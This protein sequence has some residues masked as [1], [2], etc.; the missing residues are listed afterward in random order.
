MPEKDTG[1][2]LSK[3][4]VFFEKARKIA[5]TDNFDYAI[6]MYME[7]LRCA[8]DAV[9]EGHVK[10]REMAFARKMKG[11]AGPSVMD[12]IKHMGGKAPL[13]RMIN[14]EYLFAKDP[15]NLKYAEAILNAA[16]SGGYKE[17]VKWIADTIFQANN[18]TD[19]PSVQ[20]YILLKD[21]YEEIGQLE[22]ALMAC[23]FALRLQKEDEELTDEFKRLSAELTVSKG[24]YDQEG[25]FRQ[26]IKGREE[27]ERM[28]SQENTVKTEECRLSAVEHARKVLAQDPDLVINIFNLADALS[29]M[30][31]NAAESEA[32]E[33]LD[34]AHKKTCDFSF[35]R[36]R[37]QIKIKQFKRMIKETEASIVSNPDNAPG[38]A[39]LSELSSQLRAYELEHFRSCVQNYPTDL[40]SKYEYG[41]RLLHN[42]Q[43]DDAIPLFQDAKKDPR[44]R[45]AAMDKAGLCFF[46]KGWYPDAIEVFTKALVVHELK[47]DGIAKELQYN[48]AR[49]YEESGDAEKALELYRKIAQFDFGYK[50]VHMRIDNLRNKTEK[51]SS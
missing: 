39:M 32:M 22:R 33:L 20:T 11:G 18:N 43:Y 44:Y 46:L 48:L 1:Q 9:D 6:D 42:K 13:E 8:P 40:S 3:A 31:D 24:R 14:A 36:R 19:K 30:P 25:D 2:D 10:L 29:D 49:T 16:A 15:G 45:I 21:R 34:R 7:G 50:D 35:Q 38:K 37:G 51:S 17:T 23:Q 27:Q 4:K 12:K 47:D 26:S 5:E 41:L 28:Q